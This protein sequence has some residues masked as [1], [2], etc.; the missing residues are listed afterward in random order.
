HTVHH[1]PAPSHSPR[2]PIPAPASF[3]T[4]R[5]REG[6]G[7]RDREASMGSI[8][9][10]LLPQMGQIGIV[11]FRPSSSAASPPSPDLHSSSFPPPLLC[12]SV[13]LHFVT[14]L[15]YQFSTVF[16]MRAAVRSCL[17]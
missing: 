15:F 1:G 8:G 2:R 3:L 10:P 6:E 4:T 5:V 12:A 16:L 13:A 17:I 9:K 14:R 7:D 11:D